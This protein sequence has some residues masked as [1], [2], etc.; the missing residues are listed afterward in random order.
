MT[1]LVAL[2]RTA[3]LTQPQI[4]AW[5]AVLG[6]FP[7]KWI[8]A[9]VIEMCLTETRFPEVGDLYTI[10]RRRMPKEYSALGDGRETERPSKSEVKAVAE[11]L[12]LEV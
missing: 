7:E 2:K 4:E 1:A 12:G 8:N 10:C 6:H 5:Y 9:A 3:S 11:R